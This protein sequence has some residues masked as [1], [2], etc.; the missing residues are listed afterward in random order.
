MRLNLR[1]ISTLLRTENIWSA[2][3]G[4]TGYGELGHNHIIAATRA[5][6]DQQFACLIPTYDHTNMAIV[7]IES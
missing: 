4:K 7:R 5:V 6:A 1:H 3:C 2:H